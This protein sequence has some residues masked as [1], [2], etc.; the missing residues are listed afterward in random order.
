MLTAK[1]R[2]PESDRNNNESRGCKI[3]ME[4]RKLYLGPINGFVKVEIHRK[5]IKNVHLK[6]FRSLNVFL[7]VPEQVPDD[8]IDNFLSQRITWIDE[9]ITK[10]KKSSGYNN[11][12]DI[13]NGLSIQLLGKN[14]RIIKAILPENYVEVD[15]KE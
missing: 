4:E 15:K 10:Y 11:S 13:R 1:K 7:S 5:K 8:W 12:S 9:Q 2:R 14:M 3:L 6:V